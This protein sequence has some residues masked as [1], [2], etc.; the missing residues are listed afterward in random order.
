MHKQPRLLLRSFMKKLARMV[1]RLRNAFTV[2]GEVAWL[3]GVER[4]SK[5]P[6]RVCY[7]GLTFYQTFWA[8][9]WF[10]GDFRKLGQRSVWLFALRK[11][12]TMDDD[13][14]DLLV[15]DLPWPYYQL[16]AKH[17][18][19][20]PCWV[21]QKLS[22]QGSWEDVVARF[23]KNTRSTDLRKVRKYGLSYQVSREKAALDTFYHDMYLPYTAKRFG[24]IASFAS[25]DEV[26]AYGLQPGAFLQIVHD[27][28]AVAGVLVQASGETMGLLH[29][30]MLDM[31][32]RGLA[33]AVLSAIYVSAI[34]Y[35]H[36]SGCSE[37]SFSLTRPVLSDGIYRYKRKWGAEVRD[38]WQENAY[39]WQLRKLS[40][41]TL[42]FL[43]AYPMIIRTGDGLGAVICLTGPV[44]PEA[45]L[46]LLGEYHSPGL[47]WIHVFSPCA[48]PLVAHDQADSLP[49]L[50]W[51][52]YASDSDP[53]R[54][55]SQV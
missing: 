22:L 15:A 47:H 30:G 13:T 25:H 14:S 16:Y 28:K 36:A 10:D 27:G 23:R 18:L 38:G 37:F 17:A 1:D 12:M 4:H 53:A 48:D 34:G 6:M 39:L 46:K 7:V 45:L 11:V 21:I 32:D 29:F 31:A 35:A 49:V 24:A 52:Q 40:P 44:E 41:A 8:T 26:C 55:F 5:L 43:V 33:D 54:L 51:T 42:A 2:K 19:Q 9:Q 50:R 20:M 3:E